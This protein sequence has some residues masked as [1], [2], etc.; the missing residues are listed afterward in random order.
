MFAEALSGKRDLKNKVGKIS[1][2]RFGVFYGEG[3]ENLE[4]I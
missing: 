3:L 2:N 4:P 1:G